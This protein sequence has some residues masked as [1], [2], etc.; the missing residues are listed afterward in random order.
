MPQP[1]E[2]FWKNASILIADDEP[3]MR[4]IFSAWLR[5]LGCT[6]TEVADGKEALDALLSGKFDAL[7]TDVRMPRLNG[8]ELVRRLH[9]SGSHTPVIIFV[10]GFVDLP[11]PDAYDLGVEA[12]L[13]KPCH[14][15]ELI[16]ALRR[17]I[18][19]RHLIFEPD[20][21]VAAPNNDTIPL[22][23]DR[24]LP[25]GTCPVAVGRGG[26]SAETEHRLDPGS[27]VGFS[28]ASFAK[29]EDMP[30]PLAG[31]GV[32]RWCELVSEH[33][34]AGI[35]FMH[36]ADE[37]REPFAKW[38]QKKRPSSFIPKEQHGRSSGASPGD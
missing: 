21:G 6:V 35:E 5:S 19:R 25:S 7:V 12:V 20:E 13:S 10:S 8:I 29:D 9:R 28:F 27:S 23:L 3:D 31:W 15:K 37:S 33:I 18:Q 4:E 32:V 24:Q 14:R 2:A 11:L 36:L 38:L 26:I 34:R 17:S 16:G 1:A 30:T 22:R